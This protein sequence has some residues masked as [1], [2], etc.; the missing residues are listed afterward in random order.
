MQDSRFSSVHRPRRIVGVA[1]AAWRNDKLP[2]EPIRV[3]PQH[4]VHADD[5]PETS[6]EVLRERERQWHDLALPTFE[7]SLLSRQLRR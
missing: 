6:L 3:P 1:D 5:M 2:V 7:A 4:E